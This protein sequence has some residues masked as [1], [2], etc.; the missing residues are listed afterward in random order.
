[1]FAVVIPAN[2]GAKKLHKPTVAGQS[3]RVARV[4]NFPNACGPQRRD[5]RKLVMDVHT[6]SPV[7]PRRHRGTKGL[8][9]D[10]H[11][12]TRIKNERNPKDKN[13]A[14]GG[15]KTIDSSV[16][17][18]IAL[19]IRSVFICVN[20]RLLISP[21]C[22]CDSVANFLCDQSGENFQRGFF[23]AFAAFSYRADA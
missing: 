6:G 8:A 23:C 1:M 13:G 4:G 3:L 2:L 10:E 11:G 15:D 20:L 17:L 21:L 12:Y 18:P 5:T 22:L 19:M 16:L 7:S 14:N 9:I